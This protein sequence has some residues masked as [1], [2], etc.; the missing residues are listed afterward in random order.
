MDYVGLQDLRNQRDFLHRSCAPQLGW[1]GRVLQP[2][3]GS[4]CWRSSVFL[5][6]W[7]SLCPGKL[8]FQPPL[9]GHLGLL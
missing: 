9:L 2:R 3:L 6:C 8:F 4:S 1:G 5:C 7:G